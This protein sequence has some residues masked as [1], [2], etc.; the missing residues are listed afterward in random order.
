MIG[1]LPQTKKTSSAVHGVGI[2]GLETPLNSGRAPL[3]LATPQKFVPF[4]PKV[5][6]AGKLSSVSFSVYPLKI[7]AP[8][9]RE[10][11]PTTLLPG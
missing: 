2:G 3:F 9:H 10:H 4:I 6:C 1:L 7:G 8:P 5:F 11:L